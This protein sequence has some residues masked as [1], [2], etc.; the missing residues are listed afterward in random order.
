MPV[1]LAFVPLPPYPRRG[2]SRLSL[3]AGHHGTVAPET[4]S[5]GESPTTALS[6]THARVPRMHRTGTR[7]S[8]RSP[9]NKHL[10]AHEHA[11]CSRT[12]AAQRTRQVRTARRRADPCPAALRTHTRTTRRALA[13]PRKRRGLAAAT[14]Q[15]MAL[16]SPRLWEAKVVPFLADHRSGTQAIG[17]GHARHLSCASAP[18]DARSCSRT[19]PRTN[20]GTHEP[21]RPQPSHTAADTLALTL[22]KHGLEPTAILATLP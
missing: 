1:Y 10:C 20:T 3:A 2:P 13:C 12:A 19:P 16:P 18:G 6:F 9:S 7:T 14:A 8:P 11:L 17:H 21:P 22:R 15:I 4:T 5:H